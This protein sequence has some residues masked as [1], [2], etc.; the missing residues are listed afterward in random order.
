MV[1]ASS[2]LIT[3]F[4]L[5]ETYAPVLLRKRA[6]PLSNMT[7]NVYVSAVAAMSNKSPSSTS[8]LPT[9]LLRPLLL[10]VYE[11]TCA[12]LALYQA[13]VFGTLYLMFAAFPIVYNEAREWSQ[14]WGG[15]AFVGILNGTLPAVPFQPWDNVRYVKPLE[16]FSPARIPSEARLLGCCIGSISIVTG[17]CWFALTNGPEF[18][19]AVSVAAGVPFGFGVV[20]VTIGS[21][22]YLG[23]A[24]TIFAASALTVF[25][26]ARAVLATPFP[27]FVRAMFARLRTNWGSAVLALLALACAPFPFVFYRYGDRVRARCRYAA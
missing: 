7:G 19:W 27:L 23:D 20:L 9:T 1:S 13:I 17:L 18:H 3:L 24:Y 11:P 5:P 16:R 10:A 6:Q 21:T 2:L 25:I 8:S 22:N 4:A 12:L 26:C 14:G 15:L